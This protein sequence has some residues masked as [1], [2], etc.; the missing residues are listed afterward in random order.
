MSAVAMMVSEP[1]PVDVARGA[2]ESLRLLE[3]LRVDT[4]GQNL[5]R[6]RRHRVVRAREPRDRVEQ[7][8]DVLL[9]LDEPPRLLDHHVGDLHVARRLL[10]ERRRDDLGV[11]VGDACR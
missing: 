9:V 1:P 11:D 5:A 10:V 7:D 2:E 6:L 3:A 4:A 8:D